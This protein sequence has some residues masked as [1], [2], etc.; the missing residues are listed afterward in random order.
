FVLHKAPPDRRNLQSV[1]AILADPAELATATNLMR[2]SDAYGGLLARLANQL[3]HYVEKERG[4]V[5]TTTNRHLSFLATPALLA[6]TQSTSFDPDEL[7][8]GRMTVYLVLP[9]E[10]LRSQ[11]ALM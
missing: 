2:A 6:N 7:R 1:A 9:T 3:G 8:T 5:L 10:H 4:S 11:S